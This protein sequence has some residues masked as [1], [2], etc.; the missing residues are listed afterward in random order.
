MPND[1]VLMTFLSTHRSEPLSAIVSEASYCSRMGIITE[2]NNWTKCKEWDNLWN[3][4]HQTIPS[5]GSGSYGDGVLKNYK[6]QKG[7]MIPSKVCL[8]DTNMTHKWIHRNWDSLNKDLKSLIY[9]ESQHWEGKQRQISIPN[10]D[11]ISH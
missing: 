7:W 10:Q 2:T 9:M 5:Q 8:T 4:L 6:K 11:S 3:C 1:D